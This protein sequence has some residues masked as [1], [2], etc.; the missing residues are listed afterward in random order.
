VPSA[1]SNDPARLAQQFPTAT[2]GSGLHAIK[3]PG[4]FHYCLVDPQGRKSH[5]S[6]KPGEG[7]RAF[8]LS[9]APFSILLVFAEDT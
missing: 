8:S 3:L 2:H 9:S 6:L 1:S 7:S 4:K 5:I